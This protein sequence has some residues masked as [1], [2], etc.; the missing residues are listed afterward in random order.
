MKK[1]EKVGAATRGGTSSRKLGIRAIAFPKKQIDLI[2][3][4]VLEKIGRT[5]GGLSMSGLKNQQASGA[6]GRMMGIAALGGGIGA[7]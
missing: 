7:A 4:N 1:V 3:T 5:G 2:S 6:G